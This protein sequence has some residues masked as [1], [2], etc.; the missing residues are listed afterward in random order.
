MYSETMFLWMEWPKT[1]RINKWVSIRGTTLGL[2]WWIHYFLNL[3]LP[4][5][6]ED[7]EEPYGIPRLNYI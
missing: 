3:T 1:K 4:Y 2:T 7:Y 6:P 5:D